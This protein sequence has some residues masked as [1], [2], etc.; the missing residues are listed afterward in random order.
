MPPKQPVYVRDLLRMR[1]FRSR[2]KSIE[3]VAEKVGFSAHQVTKTIGRKPFVLGPTGHGVE[4][5]CDCGRP[6]I[7]FC[8]K[9]ML[10]ERHFYDPPRTATVPWTAEKTKIVE[11]IGYTPDHLHY[12]ANLPMGDQY[13]K[14]LESAQWL[15]AEYFTFAKMTFERSAAVA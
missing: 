3:E 9:C 1:L 11:V 5:R 4:T 7:G 2:G 13:E 12:L 8:L 10:S 14:V 6:A 15:P